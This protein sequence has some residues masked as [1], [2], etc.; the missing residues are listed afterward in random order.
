M[1]SLAGGERAHFA[2]RSPDQIV[3]KCLKHYVGWRSRSDDKAHMA[4]P[5]V[6]AVDA[7]KREPGFHLSGNPP[8]LLRRRLTVSWR[9]RLVSG[10]ALLRRFFP[11]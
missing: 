11:R 9:K 4:S 10:E 2:V 7:L 8:V 3:S 6:A 5:A 1:Q